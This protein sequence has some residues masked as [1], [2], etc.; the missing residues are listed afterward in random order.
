MDGVQVGGM[1]SVGV[2]VGVPV[3][4]GVPVTVAVRLGVSVFS[5]GVTDKLNVEVGERVAVAV[6][7]TCPPLGA[8]M[9]ATHPMQ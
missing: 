3:W 2:L 5:T 9:I 7:F 4:V 1:K 8:T 6:S